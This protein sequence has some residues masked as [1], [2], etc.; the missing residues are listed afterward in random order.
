MTFAEE[1]VAD[2]VSRRPHEICG[3][4][5]LQLG[6]AVIEHYLHFFG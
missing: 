2:R 6:F 4:Q 5:V 1:G 3:H